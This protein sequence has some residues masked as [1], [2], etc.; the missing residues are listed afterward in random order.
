[1]YRRTIAAPAGVK[2]AAAVFV[3][4]R[5]GVEASEVMAATLARVIDEE[6]ALVGDRV[7]IP[8]S[9]RISSEPSGRQVKSRWSQQ[10]SS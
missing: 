10:V 9:R 8:S 6:S 2:V 5:V 3:D 1:M 7:G 4:L